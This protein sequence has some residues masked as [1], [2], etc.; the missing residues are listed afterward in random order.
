MPKYCVTGGC[1][2]IG[3]NLVDALI[4]EGHQVVVLDN[5]STGKLENLN[6][7]AQLI[8]GDVCNPFDVHRA[9]DEAD[10]CFHLAAIA[11][12]QKSNE[13]WANT[14]R[15][16]LT[17]TI[18]VFE[19]AAKKDRPVPVVFASSAAVYGDNACVPLSEE[20]KPSPITAY[21]ADKLGAELHGRV[22]SLVHSVPNF[23]FRFFNVYGPRQDPR[24]PYSGV[25]SIFADRILQGEQLVIFGDGGQSRDFIYVAD[26]VRFL[27]AGMSKCKSGH[28]VFN[29]CTGM[30]T[31]IKELAQSMIRI[32]G[33]D[34]GIVFEA[35]R[36]G[37]IR[38]SLGNPQKA[39]A[40]FGI[41]P[42]VRVGEGLEKVLG[43]L[44]KERESALD[45]AE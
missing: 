22:A 14:H 18:Q 9:M 43:W 15:C 24:S 36:T 41:R 25:M 12:V 40:T 21:G 39:I 33:R 5:L 17:G 6:P 27:M 13:D 28:D 3:S 31:T 2:F 20:D 35:E 37:D 19:A 45:A 44:Q 30:Q 11:S 16:N 7:E 34:P 8:V 10:G 26:L 4:D 38:L 23:G 42:D 32:V 29:I 1:G